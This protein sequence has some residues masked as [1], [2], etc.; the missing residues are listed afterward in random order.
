[1]QVQLETY[2]NKSIL[3]YNAI[4]DIYDGKT[5]LYSKSNPV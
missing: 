2:T 1:M 5:Y 3:I 4:V